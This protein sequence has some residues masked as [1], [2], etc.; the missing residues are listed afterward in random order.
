MECYIT[1]IGSYKALI[2][3]DKLKEFQSYIKDNF[4]NS[5]FCN[6]EFEFHTNNY[7]VFVRS[8]FIEEDDENIMKFINKLQTILVDG[9]IYVYCANEGTLQSEF[10]YM[11]TPH[12]IVELTPVFVR[13]ELKDLI[14]EM[15]RYPELFGLEEGQCEKEDNNGIHVNNKD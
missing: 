10:C 9:F 14:E 3:P 1:G 6:L 8:D 4:P 12:E 7:L 5:D 13:K 11:I 2:D 15:T